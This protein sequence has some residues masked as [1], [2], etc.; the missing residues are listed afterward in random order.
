MAVKKGTPSPSN[1]AA[2]KKLLLGAKSIA[3][4]DPRQYDR[5]D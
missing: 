5:K 3:T 1:A 2:V 4:V